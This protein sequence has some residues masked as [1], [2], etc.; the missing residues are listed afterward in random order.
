MNKYCRACNTSK[1]FDNFYRANGRKDGLQTSCK[2]CQN[3]VNRKWTATNQ[4]RFKLFCAACDKRFFRIHKRQFCSIACAKRGVLY[5][6]RSDKPSRSKG[7]V[8]VY[9]PRRRRVFEHVLIAEKILGRRLAKGEVVHHINGDKSD[10][11]N[12]NL[13]ICT[14]SYHNWLH[15]RMS[16]LYQREHF[17]DV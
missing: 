14:Q 10:N 12:C 1:S 7:Y 9:V 16:Y 6:P 13:L 5:G 3:A 2:P 15:G 8:L 4:R 11:R 17:K